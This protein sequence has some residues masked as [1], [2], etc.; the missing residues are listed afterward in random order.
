MKKYL[1]LAILFTLGIP[2]SGQDVGELIDSVKLDGKVYSALVQDGDTIILAQLDDV[3][4][5]SPRTFKS[6]E[7]YKTYMKYKRYAAKV[8]PYAKDAINILTTVEERTEDMGKR[9]KKKYIKQTYRQLEHN[10]KTQLT[11]LSKTQGRILVKMIEKATG[12]TFYDIIKDK[13]NGFTAFYWHQFGKLYD[14]DLKRGY[15]RGDDPI[16]DIV[17][18]SYDLSYGKRTNSILISK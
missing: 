10:F 16:L 11:K 17:L 12:E 1:F 14:Y 18:D 9:K 15:H 6:R 13:R 3:R 2:L 8:Y 4:F 5:S 7:E